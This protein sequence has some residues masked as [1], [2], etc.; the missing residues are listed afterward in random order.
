MK[1]TGN[2]FEK[3]IDIDNI[4][5]A[6]KNARKGKTHYREVKKVDC[7]I[8]YFAQE[9]QNMLINNTYEVGDYEVFT[10]TVDNGK[11]REIFRLDY[12]PHRIIHH[13]ILQVLE[14]IWVKTF[15]SSTYCCIRNR[16]IHK[17]LVKIKNDLHKNK[18]LKYCYKFDIRKYYPNVDNSI[19]KTTMRK[20]L[21]DKKLLLLLDKIIDSSKGLP[22]GNYMSQY[23]SNLYLNGFDHYCKEVLKLKF[24]YRY[25]DDI[26]V[27][28][29]DKTFLHQARLSIE[30]YLTK[31][32]KLEIKSNW[33][34]FQVNSR[35]I[36]FLGY[37]FFSSYT[38]LRKSIAKKVKIIAYNIQKKNYAT[39]GDINSLMSY[40]GWLI[41]ANTLNLRKKVYN[42]AVFR[43]VRESA[44]KHNIKNPLQGRY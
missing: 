29:E 6:H 20:K 22:I 28:H 38:L 4:I 15:I 30:D 25:C 42:D 26:V 12:Y 39:R 16:G 19:L 40:Y 43:L 33:Q 37:R 34:V 7:N 24:Y 18:N 35:G 44:K 1:R 17:A 31:H 27:L 8:L 3:I 13:A 41:H 9:I 21:K 10:K 36:D 11:V 5:L 2:L 23:F 32:L 14:D